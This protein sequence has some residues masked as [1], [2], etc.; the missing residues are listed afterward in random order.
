MAKSVNSVLIVAS[1][2]KMQDS[3]RS[4]LPPG[5]FDP[6]VCVP[7]GGAARRCLLAGAFDVVVINSPLTDESG[8]ELALDIVSNSHSG[9][10]MLVKEDM[11]DQTAYTVENE[12]VLCVVKPLSQSD[13]YRAIRL[14]AATA[15]RLRSTV[16]KTATLQAKMKEIRTVNRAKWI[17]IERLGMSEPDAHRYI[18]KQAMDRSVTRAEVAESVIRTYE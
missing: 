4:L 5:D 18:E 14:A 10:L 9:V 6:V 17:L 13:L 12:G 1:K 3:I 7:G 15:A 8:S 11:Y 2:D 16:K